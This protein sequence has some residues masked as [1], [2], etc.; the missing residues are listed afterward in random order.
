MAL[1]ELSSVEHIHRPNVMEKSQT[2]FRSLGAMLMLVWSLLSSS[3]Y[4]QDYAREIIAWLQNHSKEELRNRLASVRD[5]YPNSPAPLFLEAYIEEDGDR[6]AELYRRLVDQYPQSQFTDH[7]LLRL[8]QYYFTTGS[9]VVARQYLDNLV[10]QFPNSLLIP[11]AKYLAAR[12][13]I[14]S[15]Y[16]STAEQ[17]L[18]ELVKKYPKSPFK[19]QAKAALA[20]LDQMVK[21]SSKATNSEDG[22]LSPPSVPPPSKTKPYSIQIGAFS[23]RAN[24]QKLQQHFSQLGYACRIETK[25]INNSLFY[26]VRVGEFETEDQAVRFGE[27]FKNLHGIPF[28][29]VKR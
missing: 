6:A 28:Q 19:N 5:K 1:P 27:V 26:L 17:E 2:L 4:S 22:A 11:E 20:D 9:Y 16:F 29:V 18:K 25:T 15:G 10:E 21:R 12:C 23:E 24:A 3:S 13:L 14:A 8:A 7:A